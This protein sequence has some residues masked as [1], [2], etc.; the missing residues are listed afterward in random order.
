MTAPT[1]PLLACPSCGV[2]AAP[3]LEVGPGP[4]EYRFQLLAAGEFLLERRLVV[5]QTR[6]EGNE[7]EHD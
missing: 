6:G 2:C 5:I 3:R 4:G 1:L 7:P